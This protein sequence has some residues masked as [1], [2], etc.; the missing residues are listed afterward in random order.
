MVEAFSDVSL[1]LVTE[2]PDA[3]TYA[4]DAI[5]VALYSIDITQKAIPLHPVM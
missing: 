3:A 5:I 2:R 1:V 4:V